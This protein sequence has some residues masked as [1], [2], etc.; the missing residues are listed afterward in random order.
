MVK[1]VVLNTVY[2]KIFA[3]NKFHCTVSKQD[4]HNYIFVDHCINIP[5]FSRFSH[6]LQHCCKT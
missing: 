3:V 2:V 5:S 4:F 1:H 6:I